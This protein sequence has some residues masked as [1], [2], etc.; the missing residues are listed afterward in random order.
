MTASVLHVSFGV[1]N[2]LVTRNPSFSKARND[3]IAQNLDLDPDV[4]KTAY[5]ATISHVESIAEKY[6]I[7][8]NNRGVY[9]HFFDLLNVS[10]TENTRQFIVE[11]V[12]TFFYANPPEICK[13]VRDIIAQLDAKHIPWSISSNSNFVSGTVIY[14]FLQKELNSTAA[15]GQFSDLM[16]TAKPS[17][18]FFYSVLQTALN[19]NYNIKPENILHVGDNPICDGSGPAKLGMQHVIVENP[20][21]VFS[22]IIA[23]I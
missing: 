23:R 18:Q 2:T 14:P 3:L 15:G 4:V 8:F 22:T 6:G 16:Q 5:E 10:P 12:R 11:A 20:S 21:D 17:S 13:G 9:D 1:W 7:A 19:R